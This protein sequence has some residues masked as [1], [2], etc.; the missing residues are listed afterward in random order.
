MPTVAAK[1]I[2]SLRLKYP[3]E[4]M[5]SASFAIAIQQLTA[6]GISGDIAISSLPFGIASSGT[7][8]DRAQSSLKLKKC[9]RHIDTTT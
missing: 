8:C 9:D 5:E 1:P 7:S 6:L 4:G 2:A 3:I